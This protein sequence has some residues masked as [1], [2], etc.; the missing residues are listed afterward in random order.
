MS[1][2]PEES[3]PGH[4]DFLNTPL[5][6]IT[7][8]LH[9]RLEEAE[10]KSERYDFALCAIE[11]ML[12]LELASGRELVGARMLLDTLGAAGQYGSCGLRGRSM[13]D[14]LSDLEAELGRL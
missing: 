8:R 13:A 7:L 1:Y 5:P 3:A 12:S 2:P 4:V 10:K 9:E 6:T 14:L 11:R